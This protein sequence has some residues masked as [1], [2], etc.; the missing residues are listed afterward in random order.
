MSGGLFLTL[1]DL[2]ARAIKRTSGVT[3]LHIHTDTPLLVR[4]LCRHDVRLPCLAKCLLPPFPDV[5]PFLRR[6]NTLHTLVVPAAVRAAVPDWGPTDTLLHL[7]HLQHFDGTPIVVPYLLQGAPIT[8]IC[9]RGGRA[10]SNA[11]DIIPLLPKSVRWLEILTTSWDPTIVLT[12]AQT[13]PELEELQLRHAGLFV[14]KSE[15]KVRTSLL[16]VEIDSEIF[17]GISGDGSK[18]V[19]TIQ[20]SS[21]DIFRDWFGDNDALSS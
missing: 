8:K 20:V 2:A 6:N 1:F 19:S 7:P 12:A 16:A 18:S 4:L 13:L 3:S 14:I 9:L 11:T 10:G 17:L 21:Q 5:I 15:T